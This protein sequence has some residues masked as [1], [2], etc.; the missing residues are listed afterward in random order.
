MKAQEWLELSDPEDKPNSRRDC[1]DSFAQAI[2]DGAP[3]PLPRRRRAAAAWRS[4]V[5]HTCR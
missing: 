3:L 1:L 2:L 5:E 4:S